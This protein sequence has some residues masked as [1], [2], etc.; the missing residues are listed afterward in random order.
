[1]KC[2]NINSFGYNKYL[3]FQG[4]NDADPSKTKSYTVHNEGF[5]RD[6]FVK[7]EYNSYGQ[8]LEHSE[9]YIRYGHPEIRYSLSY[10]YYP[11]GKVSS[12][13]HIQNSNAIKEFYREDGTLKNRIIRNYSSI[14]EE[15]FDKYGKF[16]K[17]KRI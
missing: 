11:D 9:G 16:I 5:C 8:L 15:V 1:M 14:I 4:R 2:N 10:S 3:V 13:E 7:K 12:K 17:R 6:D